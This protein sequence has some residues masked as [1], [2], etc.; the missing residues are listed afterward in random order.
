MFRDPHE[1]RR[2]IRSEQPRQTGALQLANNN[3]FEMRV[4]LERAGELVQITNEIVR[5]LERHLSLLGPSAS[6]GTRDRDSR[7]LH[8][9]RNSGGNGDINL[10]G[11]LNNT[12]RAD[13]PFCPIPLPSSRIP[14][15]W[16]AR[17][18]IFLGAV[19][20]N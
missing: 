8:V 7:T 12:D 6:D 16:V 10:L 18:G 13:Y 11:R 3:R 19:H 17:C 5:R 9:H 15:I 14:Y 4:G 2:T 1:N 20:A